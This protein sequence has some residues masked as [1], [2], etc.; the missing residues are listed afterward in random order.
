MKNDDFGDRMK[1]YEAV[2]TSRTLD[3]M[4]PIYA[5]IDGRSFSA[6]TKGMERPYDPRMT[7][8]MIETTKALVAETH[9]RI[10][11][12]QSDEIS[13]IWLVDSPTS[14]IF[15]NGKIQKM[16]S[17]IASLATV[18]FNNQIRKIGFEDKYLDKLPHFDARIFQLP[19]L[20][21]GANA[22]L[23]REM[24]ASKNAI[25]MAA[26]A[27]Y[28]TKELHGKNSYDKL[29]MIQEKGIDYDAYP[30]SF[31]RGTFVRRVTR[32]V[33]LTPETLSKIPLLKRPNG[34][35]LRSSVEEIKLPTFRDVTNRVDVIFNGADVET[36]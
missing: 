35:V 5:R 4:L 18:N 34:P 10:G 7:K 33:T 11:Y 21:E 27:L 20:M 24:D 1:G 14:Q 8:A 3:P 9:A 22:F 29:L 36:I 26:H 32:E 13:L 15:F 30:A 2:E 28:S 17:I 16:V 23:W 31:R 25:S 12:T 19:S 6:F